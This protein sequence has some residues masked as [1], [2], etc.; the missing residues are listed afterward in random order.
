MMVG[1]HSKDGIDATTDIEGDM[2]PLDLHVADTLDMIQW[3]GAPSKVASTV[4]A[5]R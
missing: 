3:G 1:D 2:A 4:R 5:E